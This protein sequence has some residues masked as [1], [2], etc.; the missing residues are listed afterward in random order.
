MNLKI[1]PFCG[2][3]ANL[4]MDVKFGNSFFRYFAIVR[5]LDCGATTGGTEIPEGMRYSV[6]IKDT[7]DIVDEDS[8]METKAFR[9]AVRLWNRRCYGERENNKT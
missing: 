6:T 3:E 9:S 7:E 2:V 4:E 8:A 5:C 1:C